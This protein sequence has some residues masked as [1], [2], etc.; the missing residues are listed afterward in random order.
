MSGLAEL[1]FPV[2]EETTELDLSNECIDLAQ[3]SLD[4]YVS[5]SDLVYEF[6]DQV[7]FIKMAKELKKSESSITKENAEIAF[8]DSTTKSESLW[9]KIVK[10]IKEWCAKVAELWGKIINFFN[11]IIYV[12]ESRYFKA[13]STLIEKGISSIDPNDTILVHK[14]STNKPIAK[15]ND[16]LQKLPVAF[17]KLVTE[18]TNFYRSKPSE[19]ISDGSQNSPAVRES[20]DEYYQMSK[21]KTSGVQAAYVEF[22]NWLNYFGDVT[23]QAKIEDPNQIQEVIYSLFFENG[24][25]T[26]TVKESPLVRFGSFNDLAELLAGS[27]IS[28]YK[29]MD[30]LIKSLNKELQVALTGLE[31]FLLLKKPEGIAADWLEKINEW[32]SS[33]ASVAKTSLLISHK[34]GKIFLVIYI[35]LRKDALAASEAYYEAA[36]KKG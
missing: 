32:R 24:S 17:K 23:N 13:N 26:D 6:T 9:Q 36:K 28:L 2:Y 29:E 18:I 35:K 3:E 34:L 33:V 21:Y 20:S 27:S 14:Y 7:T 11:K 15:Y 5:L 31:E 19:Y 8:E 4:S 1:I 10:V 30:K 12:R 25:I 22:M 16:I